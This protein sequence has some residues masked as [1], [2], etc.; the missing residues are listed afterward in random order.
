[1]LGLSQPRKKWLKKSLGTK[2]QKEAHIRAKPVLMG[3]DRVLAQASELIKQRPLRASLA[4]AEIER[5]AEYHFAVTLADD[6]D[7]RREGTG[8]DELVASI[9]RQLTHAGVEFEMPFPLGARREYGLSDREVAK[10]NA[11]LELG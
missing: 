5:V 7:E 9:A 2:D 1:M 4:Q 10:R 3:F 11:D 6:E 8:S